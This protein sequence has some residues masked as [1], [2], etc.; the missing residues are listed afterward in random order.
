[1][2]K[3]AFVRP[4]TILLPIASVLVATGGTAYEWRRLKQLEAQSSAGRTQIAHIQQE[5]STYRA[6]P[7]S[8]KYPTAPKTPREQALFLDALRANAD[9]S[10]VQLV[11]W[12]NTPAPAPPPPSPDKPAPPTSNVTAIQSVVE[13]AGK[14]ANSR[15]FMY[16][17]L[18]SRRLLNMAEIKWVR[19][20]WPNTHLTF[21]LTRYIA[22]PDPVLPGAPQTAS[23]AGGP[24]GEAAG[25]H[26]QNASLTTSSPAG[27]GAEPGSL[28]LPN[29]MDAPG[30]AHGP[31]QSRLDA[32]V[33]KLN[34]V[35]RSSSSASPR[36]PSESNA[37]R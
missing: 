9:F 27:G 21:T 15:Q 23:A 32:G 17:V 8:E 34:E 20:Q 22:P 14:S 35:D 25:Q 19:D 24:N 18:R 12:S 10:G 36:P 13:V 28:S 31:Y 26:L 4:L 6:Q 5:M 16:N 37:K 30:I 7:P 29:P 3:E 2:N 33:S 11:R 1:M